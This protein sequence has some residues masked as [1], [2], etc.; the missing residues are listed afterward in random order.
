MQNV[1]HAKGVRIL[2]W[3]CYTFVILYKYYFS[4]ALGCYKA[5]GK[6][7]KKEKGQAK[8]KE[9]EM[10]T[11]KGQGCYIWI[12]PIYLFTSGSCAWNF[13]FV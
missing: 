13:T 3:N 11:E 2:C 5:K 10:D 6:E 8:G 9:M 4:L 1:C 7:Q 12:K